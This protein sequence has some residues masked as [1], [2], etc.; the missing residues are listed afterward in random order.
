MCQS[1][2]H[3]TIIK[4]YCRLFAGTTAPC[5]AHP[6]RPRH[7]AGA[8]WFVD[9]L[10]CR[11]PKPIARGSQNTPAEQSRSKKICSPYTPMMSP[12]RC[13]GVFWN[14]TLKTAWEHTTC[15]SSVRCFFSSCIFTRNARIKFIFSTGPLKRATNKMYTHRLHNAHSVQI[16]S[17]LRQILYNCTVCLK[18][19]GANPKCIQIAYLSGTFISCQLCAVW[20]VLGFFASFAL[21][22]KH[23]IT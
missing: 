15:F 5:P 2:W 4:H 6:A 17:K 21:M 1:A 9:A 13:D 19:P 7:T 23:V 11:D 16:P 12:A 10:L 22:C 20:H 3:G 8:F 18:I 14:D